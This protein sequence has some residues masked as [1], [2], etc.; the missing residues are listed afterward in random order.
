MSLK[1]SKGKCDV[2]ILCIKPKK[3]KNVFAA[4]NTLMV[5]PSGLENKNKKST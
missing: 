1:C 4:G 5:K 3:K 2:I